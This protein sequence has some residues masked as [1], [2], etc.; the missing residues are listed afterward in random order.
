MGL[1]SIIDFDRGINSQ[2]NPE[3]TG[4]FTDCVNFDIDK[5]GKLVKRPKSD[6]IKQDFTE[7][8]KRAVKWVHNQLSGGSSWVTFI[9]D[10]S[11]D[12]IARY[13]GDFTGKTD[14]K[15][16]SGTAGSE[17]TRFIPFTESVRFANGITRKPGI[18]QW[19]DRQWFFGNYNNWSSGGD[20]SDFVYDDATPSYPTT[21]E[22]QTVTEDA[23]GSN[24]TGYYYY[25][26]VPVFDGYQEAVLPNSYSRYVLSNANKTLK[27][28]IK[29]NTSDWNKRIT[30]IKVYRSYS[31]T[32]AGDIEPVYY[33][34]KT[35]PVNTESDHEDREVYNS[36]M[37]GGFVYDPDFDFS[38]YSNGTYWI[39]L[40][41]NLY[42]ISSVPTNHIAIVDKV[43][44]NSS[45]GTYT[46]IE[47]DDKMWAGFYE[48]Y[49]G[50][51]TAPPDIESTSATTDGS[52][53]YAGRDVV[54]NN[55]IQSSDAQYKDWVA[56]IGSN[57]IVITDSQDDIL[58][59]NTN[60]S[61]YSNSISVY[62]Q[63][64]YYY[65]VSGSNI[66]LNFYD[67]GLLD[68]SPHPLAS[69]EKINVN[70]KYGLK[71][72]G[73][74]YCGNVR[75]D[76]DSEAEDHKDWII[77]SELNQPDILPISNFIQLDD[78]QGGEITGIDE[79][80]GDIVVFMERGIFRLNVP[81][82]DPTSWSLR[83]SDQFHGCIAPD[84]IVKVG[85]NT[86]YA[87]RENVYT[88]DGNFE[89]VGI[90]NDIKDEY[91]GISNLENSEFHYDPTKNR[92]L[93]KFGNTTDTVYIFDI[94]RYLNGGYT[95]WTKYTFSGAYAPNHFIQD[96]LQKI[97]TI[98]ET[99][100][101]GG[102]TA[103]AQLYGGTGDES[104][105]TASYKTGVVA[106]GDMG[107]DYLLDTINTSYES[108]DA[109]NLRI[110]RDR[111]T[112]H[113]NFT[114]ESDNPLTGGGVL[115]APANTNAS[116]VLQAGKERFY[117]NRIGRWANYVQV[118]LIS[119]TDATHTIVE[120]MELETS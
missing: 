42:R 83:E 90:G 112:S 115:L 12:K 10:G 14:V 80:R 88:L 70:Y 45:L 57:N 59:L 116:G 60:V 102:A 55:S 89:A 93:C 69:I 97:Y 25:K 51:S 120:K 5:R 11:S 29:F 4:K 16:L 47:D 6:M 7:T 49:A 50:T 63:D 1:F 100:G 91:Q 20:N 87:G 27:I 8:V 35:I 40:V 44:D 75:L 79:I 92:L 52:N 2:D 111:K 26:F 33:H 22:H 86:F 109:L 119:D 94:D 24:P 64:N 95:T 82:S 31:P 65:A 76:P 78:L 68:G 113:D 104:N 18:L 73:R 37:H 98:N 101:S 19:I 39:Y 54:Y 85:S 36:S 9:K 43:H 81:S 72:G 38:S 34:I 84:S 30:S 58:K 110:Y 71:S 67:Y 74:F 53:G 23:T 13:N 96:E 62:L 106:T 3:A 118:E 48:I 15:T 99:D 105:Y 46:G 17:T 41:N 77:F 103:V 117:T 66:T 107:R 28:P 108:D 56:S 21:W 32:T 114:D 61:S